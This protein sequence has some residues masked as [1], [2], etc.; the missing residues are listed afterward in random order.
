MSGRAGRLERGE[1]LVDVGEDVVDVFDADGEADEVGGDAGGPE[2]VVG[3]LAVGGAGGVQDAGARVG[4]VR[5]D[6]RELEAIH[7][8]RGGGAAALDA[9]GDDAA[10]AVGQVL[11]RQRVE[12]VAFEAG[13]VDP[14][15]ARVLFEVFRDGEGVDDA[16]AEKAESEPEADENEA[17]GIIRNKQE[18]DEFIEKIAEETAQLDGIDGGDLD[19]I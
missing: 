1:R 19:E 9:E 12:G 17:A 8:A 18:L 11:P 15:D 6:G 3:E 13:V 16:A 5:H 14:G 2:L 7:E 10:G 4:D